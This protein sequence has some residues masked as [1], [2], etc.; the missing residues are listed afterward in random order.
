MKEIFWVLIVKIVPVLT[1]ILL[2]SIGFAS[3]ALAGT[4]SGTDTVPATIAALKNPT[5]YPTYDEHAHERLAP[6]DPSKK[7]FTY[8]V[9][10]GTYSH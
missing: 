1:D 3:D 9:L 8:L 6:G 2:Y 4:A 5:A 7:A 10:T